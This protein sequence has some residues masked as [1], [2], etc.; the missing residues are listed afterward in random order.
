ML[1]TTLPAIS[2]TKYGRRVYKTNLISIGFR[3]AMSAL[4]M[5]ESA[6]RSP[7]TTG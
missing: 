5:E 1:C 7:L 3:R 2:A 4:P 6:M